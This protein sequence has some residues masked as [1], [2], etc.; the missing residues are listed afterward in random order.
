MPGFP[1]SSISTVSSSQRMGYKSICLNS[2]PCPLGQGTS[3]EMWAG[4]GVGKMGNILHKIPGSGVWGHG[5][6]RLLSTLDTFIFPESNSASGRARSRRG[7]F[8]IWRLESNQRPCSLQLTAGITP[9]PATCSRARL[10]GDRTAPDIHWPSGY[11][12]SW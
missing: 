10:D 2:L 1:R 9:G 6:G 4:L 3:V 11:T 12:W 7:L 8:G 5:P